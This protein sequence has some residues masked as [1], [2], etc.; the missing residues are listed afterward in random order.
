MLPT[1]LFLALA[2]LGAGDSVEKVLS[3]S[4]LQGASI[5]VAVADAATGERIFSRSIDSPRIPA[6]NQKVIT[7]AAAICSLGPEYLFKTRLMS[8]ATL[9]EQGVLGG[10]LILRGG[11]DP[12]LRDDA[13]QDQDLDDPSRLLAEL[14]KS[15]GVTRVEGALVLDDD[16]LDRQ[17]LHPEWDKDDLDFPYA[18]PI[19]ALSI[20]GNCVTIALDGR[21]GK[22]APA[23][24]LVT[25]A[26]GYTLRNE[27]KWSSAGRTFLVGALRPDD[28]GGIRLRG[29]MSRG[30]ETHEVRVPVLD[31]ALLFGRCLM[32]Q[33]EKQGI[34]VRD[35]VQ[36]EGG[37]AR[38]LG[39]DAEL[40]RLET[41][42]SLAVILANKE[43]DNSISDHLLKVLGAEVLGKGSFEGGAAATTLFL[44]DT[45]GTS[46][47]GFSMS[48]GSGLAS[49]N[50]VTARQMVD[51]LVYMNRADTE[52][53]DL[54]LRSL[55]VSGLDGS[56]RDRLTRPPYLGAVRAKS[57]YIGG[58]SALSGYVQTGSGRILAFSILIN[59][60]PD[61]VSNRLMKTVQDDICRDLV[62]RF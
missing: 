38:N 16:F 47:E 11:G 41:P 27:V 32:A 56:L 45:V 5:S 42:L 3:R 13:L 57:G 29:R 52:V 18:A 33:L 36:R 61:G 2:L 20:Y 49:S 46:T 8:E 1:A 24:H 34:T 58:V 10:D 26:H 21:S 12:C 35:G 59:D 4:T 40:V 30:L 15:R 7:T 17:W 9:D 39:S 43:S 31:G 50:R 6:S 44:A 54:F 62:D 28:G 23:A 53:R 48:D 55:P 14:L 60:V 51:T 22:T 25:D 37:A 19:S